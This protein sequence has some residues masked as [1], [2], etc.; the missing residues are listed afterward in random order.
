MIDHILS[1]RTHLHRFKR[2]EMIH[3]MLLDLKWMNI[4]I[5]NRKMAGKFQNNWRFSKTILNNTYIKKDILRTLW[6]K[7]KWKN[8]P[9]LYGI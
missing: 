1:H 9:K 8:L 2:I 5:N 6:S 3:S 7:W 4:E